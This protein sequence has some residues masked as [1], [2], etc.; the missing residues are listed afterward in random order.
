MGRRLEAD[1][2]AHRDPRV[3]NIISPDVWVVPRYVL[4]LQADEVSRSQMHPAGRSDDGPGYALRFPRIVKEREK[5][6]EDATSVEEI[7]ELNRMQGKGDT[8]GKRKGEAAVEAA[9]A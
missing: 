7:I 6:P 9:E 2:L 1:K 5:T 8:R 3:V 4:E